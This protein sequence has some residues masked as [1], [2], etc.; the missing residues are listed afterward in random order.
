LPAD[1]HR[2]SK[3]ASDTKPAKILAI[4]VKD[5]GAPATLPVK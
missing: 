5:Q 4:L 1:V 3:N 2:V